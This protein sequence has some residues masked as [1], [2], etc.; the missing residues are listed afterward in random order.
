MKTLS[1]ILFATITAISAKAQTQSVGNS[2]VNTD[3]S[4]YTTFTWARSGEGDNNIVQNAIYNEL[5]GRGYRE[6]PEQG[7]LIV[8][9][10]VLEK[11]GQIHGYKDDNPTTTFTGKQLRLPSDTTTFSIAPGTM[12]VNM[13]DAKTGETVWTGFSSGVI[14]QLP[15]ADEHTTDEMQ[16]REAVHSIFSEFKYDARDTHS[17]QAIKFR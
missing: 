8:T 3:F 9:Y 2:K 6:N 15:E 1:V 14:H 12:M 4:K 11:K 10:R 7:D 13:I 17:R 16:L 5:E